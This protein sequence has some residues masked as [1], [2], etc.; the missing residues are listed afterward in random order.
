MFHIWKFYYYTVKWNYDTAAW[1]YNFVKLNNVIL[2]NDYDIVLISL[3]IVML[4]A[5]HVIVTTHVFFNNSSIQSS[6]AGIFET[7]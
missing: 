6:E 1:I 3:Y 2:C 7:T 5:Q 4:F